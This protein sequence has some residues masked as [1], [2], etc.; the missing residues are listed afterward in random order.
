MKMEYA[1]EYKFRVRQLLDQFKKL[2][3]EE[4]A[5]EFRMLRIKGIRY[6]E[7]E[8]PLATFLQMNGYKVEVRHDVIKI[9]EGVYIFMTKSVKAFVEEFDQGRFVTL[10]G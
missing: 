10:M 3:P 6:N 7:T 2:T 9:R 5:D 1:L 4:I 8:C